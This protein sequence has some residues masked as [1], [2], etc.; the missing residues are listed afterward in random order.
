[1]SI[2]PTARVMEGVILPDDAQV[3]AFCLLGAGSAESDAEIG[4]GCCIRSHTV[5]YAGNRIG[6]HFATGHHVMIRELNEIGDNV[7]V[8][9]GSVIEHHVKIGDGVRI[10]SQAFIPE[11]CVLED[12]CWIGPNV[13]LTNA[14]FPRSRRAKETLKGV[15]IG[16]GA[17]ICANCTILPGVR[18][19]RMALV[20]AGSVVTSDVPD[21]MVVA[22]NP[23][24]VLKPVSELREPDYPDECPYP[25]LSVAG[26]LD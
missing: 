23:A 3:G 4:L 5:I 8:G 26:E 16:Q 12:E 13:V 10:H 7:S 22:G 24:T 9:T 20:G 2:D 25:S 19:G 17:K 21:G 18:I 1:M 15:T 14:R 6:C 11:Y